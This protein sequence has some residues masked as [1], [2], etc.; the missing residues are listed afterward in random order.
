MFVSF[1]GSAP[2]VD[3]AALLAQQAALLAVLRSIL[4]A[5][6]ALHASA[7]D[8]TRAA[9]HVDAIVDMLCEATPLPAGTAGSGGGAAAAAAASTSSRRQAADGL[10]EL[11]AAVVS[12]SV[13]AEAI[14]HAVRMAYAHKEMQHTSTRAYTH[15]HA[16]ARTLA[17]RWMRSS[18]SRG[19]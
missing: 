1:R 5:T 8:R 2:A 10:F 18:C 12:E 11:L 13:D 6:H 15:A 14:V 19:T 7:A 9:S 17:R 4:R 16:H 3:L